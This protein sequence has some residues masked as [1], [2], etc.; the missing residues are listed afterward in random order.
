[1]PSE[2]IG[3]A[4]AG[5]HVDAPEEVRPSGIRGDRQIA[6]PAIVAPEVAGSV[7]D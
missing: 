7:S 5:S 4:P 3:S 6:D 1:M 2:K